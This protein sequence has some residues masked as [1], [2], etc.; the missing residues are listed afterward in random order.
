MHFYFLVIY[1]PTY[2]VHF[3]TIA[4]GTVFIS[5]ADCSLLLYS[6][7]TDVCELL[8]Y[9]ISIQ[10]LVAQSCLTLCDR[11]DCSPPGSSVHEIFPGKDTGVGC[12]FL[13][14][15][16]FP[17]QGLNPGLL[18]CR[19]ILYRLSYKGSLSVQFSRS[20][21]SDSLRLH[22]SQQARPPCP[23]PTPGVHSDSRPS[24]Q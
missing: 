23:S 5:F 6:N 7:M 8:F 11:R 17:T 1:S 24:S 22:E 16:I 15:G 10:V 12:H 14:Q 21:M 9:P 3:E 13:L 2:I 19:Q 18:H 20:V 4:N